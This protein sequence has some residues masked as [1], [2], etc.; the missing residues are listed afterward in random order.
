M[1]RCL[2][3]LFASSLAVCAQ[4]YSWVNFAGLPG[5][6]G[7][8]DGATGTSRLN[9]TYGA[10]CDNSGNIY[11]ADRG[12]SK[13]KK[14]TPAGVVST[15]SVSGFSLPT[16]VVV[17]K[18]NGNLYVADLGNN[19]I[20]KIV[21]PCACATTIATITAIGLGVDSTTDTVYVGDLG[22]NT[23]KKITSGGVVSTIAGNGTA[24]STDGALLS[25]KFNQPCGIAVDPTGNL[26]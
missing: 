26:W 1:K 25:A 15:L 13:I 16:H 12:N 11:I 23:I 14:I 18:T 8:V 20:K 17:N 5:T 21:S 10:D 2:L 4:T 6:P 24:G 19:A 9:G 7:D 3:I 22:N